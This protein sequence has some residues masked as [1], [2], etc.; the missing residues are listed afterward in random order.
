MEQHDLDLDFILDLDYEIDYVG[1]PFKFA[2]EDL[3]DLLSSPHLEH[4]PDLHEPLWVSVCYNHFTPLKINRN[5]CPM[6]YIKQGH[7]WGSG[8]FCSPY[9]NECAMLEKKLWREGVSKNYVGKK[10]GAGVAVRARAGQQGRSTAW[11]E[12]SIITYQHL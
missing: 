9:R 3:L 5:I 2:K 8:E 10:R 4:R 11:L 1:H 6:E 12:I 7:K